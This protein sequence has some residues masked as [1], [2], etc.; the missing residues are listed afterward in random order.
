MTKNFPKYIKYIFIL[1]NQITFYS[2]KIILFLLQII[3][4]KTI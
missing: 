2:N 4:T 3:S 1:N